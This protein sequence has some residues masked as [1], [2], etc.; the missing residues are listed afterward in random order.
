MP[1]ETKTHT[2]ECPN[3]S[4]TLIVTNQI[5]V[6]PLLKKVEVTTEIRQ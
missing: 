2:D 3:C 1:Q 6:D 5:R 4:D